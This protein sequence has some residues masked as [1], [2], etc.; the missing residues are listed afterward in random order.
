MEAAPIIKHGAKRVLRLAAPAVCAK[1]ACLDIA[2][3]TKHQMIR[4]WSTTSCSSPKSDWGV[5]TG[6]NA[7]LGQVNRLHRLICTG[8][9]AV[10]LQL[11]ALL[12]N[13]PIRALVPTRLTSRW[14]REISKRLRTRAVEPGVHR[15]SSSRHNQR[16]SKVTKARPQAL[17]LRPRISESFCPRCWRTCRPVLFQQPRSIFRSNP[18]LQS[19]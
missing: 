1:V 10:K 19:L 16:Y 14:V 2:S 18:L 3:Q 17:S 15:G 13:S 9:L 6:W 11:L 8:C 5:P 7:S 12:T 4:S